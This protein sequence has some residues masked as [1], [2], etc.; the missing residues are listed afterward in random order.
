MENTEVERKAFETIKLYFE[1]QD[2]YFFQSL[3]QMNHMTLRDYMIFHYIYAENPMHQVQPSKLATYLEISPSAVSQ[4]IANYEKR[5]W[6]KRVHSDTDR[7]NVYISLTD[8]A[9]ELVKKHFPLEEDLIRKA[10]CNCS[11][12]DLSAFV[13]VLSRINQQIPIDE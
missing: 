2:T 13:R 1:L 7:R 3:R 4:L 8:E 11:P 10:I 12:E 5:N 6:V 9:H